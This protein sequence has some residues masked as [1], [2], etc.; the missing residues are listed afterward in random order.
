MRRTVGV[1]VLVTA[2]LFVAA[3]GHAQKAMPKVQPVTVTG[4]LVDT[5][6]YSMNP[7]NVGNDHDTPKGRVPSCAA[8][9]AKMGLPVG[10]RTANGQVI[11]LV[12]PSGAFADY[13][14]KEARATGAKV[15]QG[16]LRPD[17][18]EVRGADG[19]WKEISIATM[20]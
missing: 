7:A 5:K 16:S 8:A 10:L 3:A 18:V 13:M 2:G 4:V 1:W 17:K 15:Y 14:A 12:A 6:C 9:C 11:V 20:M 19:Q